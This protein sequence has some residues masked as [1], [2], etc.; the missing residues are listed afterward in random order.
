MLSWFDQN[1]GAYWVIPGIVTGGM[2]AAMLRPF[3]RVE[4]S[5]KT[6]FDWWDIS[7]LVLLA[8]GRWPTWFITRQ[9]NVDES[10]VISGAQ[11][12]RYDPIF[13][14]SVDG[15]TA[16]PLD[17]YT[18]LPFGSLLGG[19]GYAS[20]RVAAFVLIGAALIFAYR[21][22]ALLFGRQIGRIAVF[23]AVCVEAFSLHSD[24]LHYST[25]LVSVTLIA[26]ACFL[27]ARRFIVQ[28]GCG[29][30]TLG[31]LAL[32]S[33]PFAKP[34]AAP[35]G[36]FIGLTW[37]VVELCRN[38]T[39]FRARFN[40]V[41]AIVAGALVPALFLAVMVTAYDLWP[42]VV[43]TY[44]AH[45]FTYVD[46]G[47]GSSLYDIIKMTR[48]SANE[49]TALL[50]QWLGGSL[51][52]VALTLPL[53]FSVAARKWRATVPILGLVAIALVCILTPHRPFV[54]YW[55]LLVVPWT[56]LI[57]FQ[58]GY[59]IQSLKSTNR[60]GRCAVLC[61]ALLCTGAGI[62]RARAG[63]D[64]PGARLLVAYQTHRESELARELNKYARPGEALGSWGWMTHIFVEADLRQATRR[65]H[66]YHEILENPF[67]NDFRRD[68]LDDL[69][70]S[71]PPVF[72]DT[73]Q[74]SN[75][76]FHQGSATMDAL[77]PELADYIQTNY[78]FRREIRGV[79]FYVRPDRLPPSKE[80]KTNNEK[81]V[82]P[83]PS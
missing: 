56:L 69:R 78:V 26:L 5:A 1:P 60:L 4:Q 83:G 13:W 55:Q 31:A 6:K 12:L 65:S 21:T 30:N 41:V 15:M 2:L 22:I 36:A 72:V 43:L 74:V 79:L 9:L 63:L 64:F 16:G 76:W 58:T 19:D 29:W 14:R 82:D 46:A 18:L 33:V 50:V 57:G 48:A 32:G 54:H 81:I 75:L 28:A 7:V 39:P 37:I 34:Q 10:H 44:R 8:A 62:S 80:P 20:A 77:F 35:M 40:A 70:Q 38:T 47:L 53:S 17:F 3:L 23:P 24:V 71:A 11:T 45:L 61:L 52:F 27:F 51:L 67:I 42:Y 68:Y 73:A 49:G 59:A 25:E 66:T